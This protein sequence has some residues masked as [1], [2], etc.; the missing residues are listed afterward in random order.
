MEGPA[1][2]LSYML[3]GYGIIFGVIIVYVASLFIRAR[4]LRQDE[5][6]LEKMQ[7]KQGKR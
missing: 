1:N 6:I 3:A 5:E 4:N 7:E 2:T